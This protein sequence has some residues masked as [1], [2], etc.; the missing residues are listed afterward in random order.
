MTSDKHQCTRNVPYRMNTTILLSSF[1]WFTNL[2]S[3]WRF[4]GVKSSE[5]IYR[6][7]S[8]AD[9]R[10]IYVEISKKWSRR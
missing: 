9:K 8:M 6:Y 5:T 7:I 3:S 2:P 10:I 1:M 4:Y